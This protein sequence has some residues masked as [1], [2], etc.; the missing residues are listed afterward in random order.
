MPAMTTLVLP[1]MDGTGIL[2]EPFLRAL[3]S[4]LPFKVVRYPGSDALGYEDLESFVLDA[5]PSEGQLVLLGESFSGPLAV[6]L[7]ARLAGRVSGLVLCCTFVRNPRP[8]LAVLK[9]LARLISHQ[10]L[11]I[12]FTARLLLGPYATP[13]LRIL[14]RKALAQVSPAVL[15]ARLEA[16][17]AV[18]A[19]AALATVKVPVLYLQA[20]QDALVPPSAAQLALNAC[21]AMR[22]VPVRGPHCLLQA[23]PAE[24]AALVAALVREIEGAC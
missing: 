20:T 2:F 15:R 9:P 5:L 19:S 6:S 7:A 1:G 14:L 16:V 18:D 8:A 10:V 4:D 17:V 11:P 24:T 13:G 23:A 22:V 12:A 3:P 21:P